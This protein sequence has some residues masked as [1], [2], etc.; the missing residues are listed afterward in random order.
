MATAKVTSVGNSLGV[1]LPRELLARLR[2]HKGDV[3]YLSETARGLEL[4]PFNPE[5]ARQLDVAS[6]IMRENRDVLRKL[7]E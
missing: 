7:A 3:V 5:F 6:E 4:S 1:I 2:L